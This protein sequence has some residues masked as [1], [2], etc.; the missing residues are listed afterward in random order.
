MTITDHHFASAGAGA[1]GGFVCDTFQQM[2][3][4]VGEE[5]SNRLVSEIDTLSISLTMSFEAYDVFETA[6]DSLKNHQLYGFKETTEA[7]C[8]LGR[9]NRTRDSFRASRLRWLAPT[10]RDIYG[11]TIFILQTN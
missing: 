8:G 9:Y 11:G 4:S 2:R 1:A 3:L 7:C 5:A 6:M 10:P